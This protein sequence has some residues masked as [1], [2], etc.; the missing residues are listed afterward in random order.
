MGT[1]LAGAAQRRPLRGHGRRQ[2]AQ[3]RAARPGRAANA[4]AARAPCSRGS[5]HPNIARLLDAG[6]RP[7]GGPAVP[8]ARVRRGRRGSTA[9]ATSAPGS[10]PSGSR[11]FS[12]VLAAV[13]HAHANLIVHRDLKPS[14][15]LVDRRR[16]GEAA[17]LRHR[18]A[19]RR[20]KAARREPTDAHRGGRRALTP[21]YAAPEQVHGRR[22]SPPRPTSTRWAC[23]STCCSPGGTR[24]RWPGATPADHL[25]AAARHRAAAAERRRRGWGGPVAVAERPPGPSCAT[26]APAAPAAL[27]GRPG[28]HR[29]PRPSRSGPRSA[30]RRS[31]R[32]RTTSGAT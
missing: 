32:W 4:S 31:E 25:R 18:Q 3:P 20:A 14:N 11:S 22:R 24:R 1:R 8:R 19:A 17:R 26:P 27:R 7:T 29:A 10:S 30:T 16:H 12:Q 9:I 13:A 28:Q 2:A 23:C 15:I 21:E 6:R 5:T